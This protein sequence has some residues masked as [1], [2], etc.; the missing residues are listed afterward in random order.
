V[1]E[2]KTEVYQKYSDEKLN[3]SQFDKAL[4]NI[5]TKNKLLKKKRTKTNTPFNDFI[6][7]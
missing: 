3:S 7:N 5:Q 6:T 2:N 1:L 4:G